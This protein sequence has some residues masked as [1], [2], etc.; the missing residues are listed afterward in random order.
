MKERLRKIKEHLIENREIYISGAIGL[1]VGAATTYFVLSRNQTGTTIDSK[2]IKVLSPTTNLTQT[3]SMYGN[4][5]GRPG[6][7]V[8]DTITGKRYESEKLAARAVGTSAVMM[9]RH[10]NGETD[11][12]NG[13]VFRFAAEDV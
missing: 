8:F 7:P 5:L 11:S 12:V 3:I 13:A 10:L 2:N 9:S 4:P 1:V 6:K